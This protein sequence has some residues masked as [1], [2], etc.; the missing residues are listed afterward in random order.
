MD[1]NQRTF[2]NIIATKPLTAYDDKANT[3]QFEHEKVEKV[4][5]DLEL[6]TNR[7]EGMVTSL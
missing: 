2:H 6:K 5:L 7:D 3:P 4:K 1:N